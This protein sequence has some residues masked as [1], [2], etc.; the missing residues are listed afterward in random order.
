MTD[1]HHTKIFNDLSAQQVK[2]DLMSE[3]EYA[4]AF[5][6]IE[7]DL[8]ADKSSN[9]TPHL[10]YVTG[11][12]GA[13][14]STVVANMQRRYAEYANYVHVNFDALRVYHPRYGQLVKSDPVNAAARIDTA[15]EGL[16]IWLAA[17]VAQRKLNVIMDDAAMGAEMTEII[18]KPFKS[19]G[20][21][22]DATIMS[23]PKQVAQQSTA[24]R[25]IRDMA[26]ARSGATVLPRW[27][28][29][30]EQDNA[31][32]AL[33]ETAETLCTGSLAR[34][35]TLQSRGG[36]TVIF[37]LTGPQALHNGRRML[38]TLYEDTHRVLSAG[39]RA[40]FQKNSEEIERLSATLNTAKNTKKPAVKSATP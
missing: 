26:A 29:S 23:V 40:F 2:P 31:P 16:M 25:F 28:N 8:L 19:L 10:E 6:Q 7:A 17:E 21:Q 38:G 1:T 18:L 30:D 39:E 34:Q 5:A 36:A 37:P 32:A 27:V 9:G 35:V 33:I 4:V 11:L 22:I 14:K 3:A 20:Y 15:T 12:P 13:G 24:L